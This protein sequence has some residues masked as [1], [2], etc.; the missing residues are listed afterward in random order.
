MPFSITKITSVFVLSMI[1]TFISCSCA[2]DNGDPDNNLIN[3]N[4][5][6]DPEP[7]AFYY[8]ADLSYVNEMEDCGAIYFDTNNARDNNIS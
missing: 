1:L 4:P 6:T 5:D 2:N 3:S 7:S 8:G